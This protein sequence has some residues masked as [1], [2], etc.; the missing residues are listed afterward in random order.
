MARYNCL[1]VDDDKDLNGLIKEYFVS[2]NISSLCAESIA[3]ARSILLSNEFDSILLDINLGKE[4]GYDLC[5]EI[6]RDNNVPIIF[7]SCRRQDEDILRALCIG[8]DDYVTKPFSLPVL[9]AKIK[10]IIRRHSIG[11]VNL[12]VISWNC[13][14]IDKTAMKITKSGVPIS[15][16]ATEFELFAYLAQNP[17]RVIDKNEL[18]KAVW[19]DGYYSPD[20]LNV[21]I[22]KLR[23]K[24]ENT[25][26]SPEFIKTI[27]GIGYI[28]RG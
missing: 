25:P 9:S 8:G 19:G 7:C 6:R 3:D 1:I 22:R 28:L 14:V 16:S 2:K 23:E 21:Y 20:T 18:L 27:W 26:N 15:L 13:F 10:A 17:N 4:S 12:G 11:D 5:A 24:I